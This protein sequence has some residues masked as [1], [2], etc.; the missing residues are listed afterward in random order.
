MSFWEGKK[1][2]V[3]GGA[4][5]IGSYVV[6]ELVK[7]NARVLLADNY[8]TGKIT[9]IPIEVRLSLH[10]TFEGFDFTSLDHC[11]RCSR[12]VDAIINLAGRTQGIGYSTQHQGEMFFHNSA[13]QLNMLE[14]AMRNNV[15][16]YLMVSS[17]CVYPDNASLPTQEGEARGE[18]EEDNRG[19]GWAKW[20][21]EQQTKYYREEYD[22]NIAI[23]RPFNPYGARYIARRQEDSHVI[24]ALVSKVLKGDNPLIVWGSGNQTR[25]FLHASDTARLM[26]LILENHACG[27]PVN[28][29]YEQTTSIKHLANLICHISGRK[30][31][32]VFDTTKPEGRTHK[33]ADSTL[34]RMVTDNY[35]PQVELE[36]GLLEIIECQRLL[37]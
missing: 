17:S 6:E 12:G 4:G 3:A 8:E 36:D 16:R 32:I 9:N 23:C 29:G 10:R 21:G 11:L 1:V 28:I 24:P 27:E 14:A 18:P 34:L 22:M 25:N 26:L 5:F 7:Q 37:S 20:V 19:Y 15:E 31:K 30:P 13:V 2:L 33:S 35:Q